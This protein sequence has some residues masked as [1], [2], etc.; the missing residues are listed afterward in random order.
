MQN[1]SKITQDFGID[2]YSKYLIIDVETNGIGTFHPP[3]QTP[4]QISYQLIDYLGNSLEKVSYFIQGVNK[5]S[6]P[7][8]TIGKCPWSVEFINENGITIIE[9]INQLKKHLDNN[10]LIVGHNIEFDVGCIANYSGYS[11]LLQYPILCTMKTT[12]NICKLHPYR[13]GNYKYPK[14]VELAHKLR[15]K[16][17]NEKFHDS[18]YDVEITKQCL[19]KLLHVCKY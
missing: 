4:I 17:E 7:E 16:V 15:I 19:L 11:K 14:L 18:I 9:F 3:T 13:G 10:T 5:I 6:W 12:T 2:G 1:T 8:E